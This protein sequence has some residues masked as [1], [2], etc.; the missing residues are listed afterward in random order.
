[1]TNGIRMRL[2]SGAA[3]V[4]AAGALVLTASPA[5]ATSASTSVG[6]PGGNKV[7]VNAWHC[8]FYVSACDW[9]ASTKMSGTNPRK[10][11]WIQNR[12]EL[13]AHGIS[14]SLTISKNPEA[15]LT[16]KSRSLGEVRWKNTNANISDTYGQMRPGGATTYVSTRSCGSAQVTSAIKVSEKCAYAGAA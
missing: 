1:M 3:A 8:G 12:A 14:V 16:M 13:Q 7:S 11:K 5:Q 4:C 9:K 10:A 2:I 15:T 6:L